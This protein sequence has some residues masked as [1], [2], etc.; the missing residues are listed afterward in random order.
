MLNI[1]MTTY[2]VGYHAMTQKKIPL[3]L[4]QFL[5]D[6]K[7][8]SGEAIG[9]ILGISRAA[10]WKKLQGLE[11][12]GIKVQSVKGRGYCLLEPIS[13]L[14]QELIKKELFK[15]DITSNLSFYLDI[16]STNAEL[17]RCLQSGQVDDG[18]VVLAESQ[19]VGRGRRGRK[20]VSSFGKNLYFSMA[21]SFNA[22]ISSLDGLSLLVG[23]SVIQA[24]EELGLKNAK[25]KWPNDV[26]VD[27][28]K[29][30]GV[31]LEITGDPTG[32]CHV[33]IGV[34]INV[35]M[36]HTVE[37]IDQPWTS[38]SH[39]FGA[40]NRNELVVSLVTLLVANLKRFE[41][42]GFLPFADLWERYD[43]LRNKEVFVILGD[44][45]IFGVA[46][47]VTETGELKLETGDGVKIFNGGEVS[48]RRSV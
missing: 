44:K 19:Y 9:G 34:G 42:K 41:A 17:L 30:A 35:N 36:Q 4:L 2:L 6:G 25:L 32:L 39:E 3:E 16:D 14:D 8:H 31:L 45:Q 5:A 27:N 18:S 13:V 1:I 23:L 26:L 47:G 48:L 43:L 46:R 24:L 11:S 22:G 37:S 28:K 10:V 12:L 40:I 15:R 21:W 7:F 33:V 20:W 38:V 29:L